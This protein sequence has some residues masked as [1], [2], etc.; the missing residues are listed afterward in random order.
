MDKQWARCRSGWSMRVFPVVMAAAAAL[1]VPQAATAAGGAATDGQ[2]SAAGSLVQQITASAEQTGGAALTSAQSE[3]HNAVSQ[4]QAAGSAA[5]QSART[6]AASAVSHAESTASLSTGRAAAVSTSAQSGP[7]SGHGPGSAASSLAGL[8]T[9][10]SNGSSAGANAEVVASRAIA[11]IAGPVT[12]DLA[13]ARAASIVVMSGWRGIRIAVRIAGA[14]G[15]PLGLIPALTLS[16][17]REM[18]LPRGGEKARP[19]FARLGGSGN[20]WL[21]PL[22]T[23]APPP[24]RSVMASG[25]GSAGALRSYA[26]HGASPARAAVASAAEPPAPAWLGPGAGGAFA[27]TSAGGA[28]GAALGLLAAASLALLVALSSGRLSLELPPM[29]STLATSPLERPG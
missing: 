29:R 2:V 27:A 17:G 14:L 12:L 21:I 4:A 8:T 24:G 5:L 10:G 28:G 25:P 18:A 23:E 20:A 11:A 9:S 16:R 15:Q 1:V 7:G 22:V 19:A 26:P 3:V 13:A 6:T